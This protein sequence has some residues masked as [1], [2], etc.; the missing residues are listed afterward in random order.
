MVTEIDSKKMPEKSFK[1]TRQ[2]G[3]YFYYQNMKW[4][5][6]ARIVVVD[7]LFVIAVVIEQL[8]RVLAQL[9]ILRPKTIQR[10]PS[11]ESNGKIRFETAPID[12]VHVVGGTFIDA[13]IH[14]CGRVNFNFRFDFVLANAPFV[15]L[16]PAAANKRNWFR[17]KWIVIEA[18]VELCAQLLLRC[19][20]RAHPKR[21]PQIYRW[22][23]VLYTAHRPSLS[24][25]IT[26]NPIWPRNYVIANASIGLNGMRCAAEIWNGGDCIKQLN[27]DM[28]CAATGRPSGVRSLR[29]CTGAGRFRSRP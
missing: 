7:V 10:P 23:N 1:I 2:I 9:P 21:R 18:I 5:Q 24:L 26:A 8:P 29:A 16:P 25:L 19:W 14:L 6:G 12:R 11:I 3:F 15:H 13:R 27:P 17:Y 28:N 22:K 4:Q 20:R